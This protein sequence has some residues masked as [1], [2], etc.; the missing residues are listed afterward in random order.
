[1]KLRILFSLLILVS[2]GCGV[3]KPVRD[4]SVQYVL[5]PLVPDRM[6]TASV[7]AIGVG[8]PSLPGFLDSQQLVTRSGNQ[9]VKSNL[10]LWAEPL[11]TAIAR[12]TASN[13]RRLTASMNI[14]P[15]ENFTTLD[16]ALLL[17]MKIAQFG[18]TT[19]NEILFEG[20]WKLQPVSG[21][22]TTTH[23]FRVV[24]PVA[25][26]T[27]PMEGRINAMNQALEQLARQIVQK[28]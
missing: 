15:V 12:V 19:A 22:A 16:Y 7:P 14:Q 23:F 2:S 21:A 5:A 8:R 27:P 28:Q 10:A 20:T 25:M 26:T 24:V 13:L 1:M 6:P 11:D 4:I 9:L 18:P 17:E 3:L